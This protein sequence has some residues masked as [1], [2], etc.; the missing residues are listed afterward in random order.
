MDLNLEVRKTNPLRWTG[1]RNSNCRCEVDDSQTQIIRRKDGT[2][3][4]RSVTT[5][6]RGSCQRPR[7]KSPRRNARVDGLF[8]RL[9]PD[10][11]L[12]ALDL[13]GVEERG[14]STV[15]G[16]ARPG[17]LLDVLDHQ[18]E[19]WPTSNLNACREVSSPSDPTIGMIGPDH[20]SE[21][22]SPPHPEVGT[23]HPNPRH[24]CL[25][26]TS[27]ER[28]KFRWP[29]LESRDW[30]NIEAGKGWFHSVRSRVSAQK[31]ALQ[32]STLPSTTDGGAN[33]SIVV[34]G[35]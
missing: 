22:P 2:E 34:V 13:V 9:T 18:C 23:G 28:P 29:S 26:S 16:L 3:I 24:G 30:Y 11:N 27:T 15:V 31:T 6:P 35:A 7:R 5:R 17:R 4:W 33:V 25:M 20:S 32:L 19:T 14:I 1:S 8:R 10:D 12:Q 21:Q